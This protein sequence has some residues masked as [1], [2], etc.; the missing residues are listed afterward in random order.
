MGSPSPKRRAV[1]RLDPAGDG[2][3]ARAARAAGALEP[4]G[5]ARHRVQAPAGLGQQARLRGR[6]VARG[7]QGGDEHGRHR[8]AVLRPDGSPRFT[9][10]GPEGRPSPGAFYG[11]ILDTRVPQ[12]PSAVRVPPQVNP[13]A[14][15]S[16]K[17]QVCP[18]YSEAIQ[19]ERPSTAAAP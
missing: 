14:T 3:V 1:G 10:G 6:I 17:V 19:T 15:Y 9:G 12:F 16:S 7:A 13:E 4:A 8:E 2:P 18:M 5:A 11:T